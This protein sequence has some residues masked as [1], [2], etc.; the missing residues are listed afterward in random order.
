[1]SRKSE[2]RGYKRSWKN[3]LINKRYQLRF[4]MFMVV[5]AAVLM[6]G[7]G[8]WVMKVASTATQVGMDLVNSENC[9]V[10]P[11]VGEDT[12]PARMG[13]T[14]TSAAAAP[15]GTGTDSA[16]GAGAAVTGDGKDASAN[17]EAPGDGAPRRPA[18]HIDESTLVITE[19][20][21]P[22]F[23]ALAAGKWECTLRKK[24]ALRRLEAGRARIR[25]ALIA[26]GV[27]LVLG[28]IAYGIKAT[29]RVAGPL[30]KVGLYLAKMKNGRYDTVY[31]LR[32][33]DQLVAFYEHFRAAHAGIVGMQKADIQFLRAFIAAAEAEKDPSLDLQSALGAARSML[34]EKE[35]SLE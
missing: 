23:A 8:T 18:V 25:W 4:T 31:P 28:L 9:P 14:D 30:Y 13:V 21:S 16:S 12:T 27:V 22:Q 34:A 6:A 10:V 7:L 33:G 1:M 11:E 29:H 5:L 32:K 19:I 20:V 3:L 15:S 26:T 35:K 17:G 2:S 24:A